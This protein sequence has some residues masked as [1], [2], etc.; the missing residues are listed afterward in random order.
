MNASAE[1]N[2]FD[3]LRAA[4]RERPVVSSIFV[5]I[6]VGLNVWLDYYRFHLFGTLFDVIV[7]FAFFRSYLNS[8]YRA[9]RQDKSR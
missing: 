9:E 5:A 1:D 3:A 2:G 4:F 7:V 6:V 8:R